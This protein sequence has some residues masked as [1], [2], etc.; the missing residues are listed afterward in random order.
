[1]IGR[2]R[3][4]LLPAL[5]GAIALFTFV[6]VLPRVADYS[7]VW[8]T[9]QTLTPA[10]LALLAV[11]T[12]ANVLTYAPPYQAA[13]P[14]LGFRRALVVSQ[15]ASASSYIAPGGAAT[16][17]ALSYALLR[18]WAFARR[19]VALALA[20]MQAFN[21][22][23]LL[24]APAAALLLL[25][26]VGERNALLQT[27]AL[28]GLALAVLPISAFVLALASRALAV[29]VGDAAAR[30]ASWTTSLV[31]REPVR[32]NGETLGTFRADA[33]ALLRRRAWLLALATI[34]GHATVFLV[35]L[36]TLRTLDVPATDVSGIE[37]FAAWALVRLLGSIPIT[38]GGIGI[39]ELG[40]TGVLT[41]FGGGD[42]A[43]VAAVL[44][45]RVL[46]LV[47]TIALGALLG[48]TWRR[49]ERYPKVKA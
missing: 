41:E 45:Y 21:Q 43:V 32:W 37:A 46:T 7:A 42:A 15:A 23:V 6:Y 40:L 22:V 8:R 48:A 18:G 49:A 27:V 13:L 31:G 3:R 10:Q 19:R 17:T 20:A 14:G 33:L 24:S 1:M 25:T 36:A 35:L 39:V 44:L 47:P 16:A 34:G 4:Y 29:R 38:P 5:G 2:M 30:V 9:I 11:A 12:A 28:A 26:L